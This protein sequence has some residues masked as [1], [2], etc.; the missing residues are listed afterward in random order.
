RRLS[1]GSDDRS[2]LEAPPQRPPAAIPK[3][4]AHLGQMP[5]PVNLACPVV[6]V[7][8]A[9]RQV[10]AQPAVF[11][12]VPLGLARDQ[13][14]DLR[15]VGGT[16]RVAGHHYSPVMWKIRS[17]LPWHSAWRSSSVHSNASMKST[18]GCIGWSG[19]SIAH[20]TLAMPSLSIV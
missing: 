20:I 13:L 19:Y 12:D 16:E 2:P 18:A 1:C 6:R 15:A 9:E 14:E 5:M 11:L 7:V 10:G 8:P 4:P 3:T 17:A